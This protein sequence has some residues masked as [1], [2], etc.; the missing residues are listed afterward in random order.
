MQELID[1]LVTHRVTFLFI[2]LGF[3][4]VGLVVLVSWAHAASDQQSDQWKRQE[5]KKKREEREALAAELGPDVHKMI[6]LL[7]VQ[8]EIADLERPRTSGPR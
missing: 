2:Y 7:N 1:H 4:A 8:Q 6:R 5:L 3:Q